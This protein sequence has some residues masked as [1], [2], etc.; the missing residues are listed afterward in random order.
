MQNINERIYW[1]K[2]SKIQKI[3]PYLT[4]DTTCDVVIIGG[5]ISG[6]LT[7]YFLAKAGANVVVIEKNIV[8]YGATISAPATLEY[9][10]DMDM[11]KL[12]KMKGAKEANRIYKICLEAIDIIEKIDD[13]FEKPTGFKR[14]DSIYF[15]NKFM[16]K[17]NMIK[18]FSARKEAGFDTLFLDSHSVLNISSA[19]L[20]KNASAV[21]NPYMFTQGLFEYLS[22][23]KNVRIY[24]N[25]EIRKIAPMYDR[26]ECK[27]NNDFKITSNSAIFTSG[28]ETLKYL[29]NINV[30]L[31]KSFS[32]VTKPLIDKEYLKNRN[33]NFTARESGDPYHYIRFDNNGRIIFSGENTKMSEKFMDKKF[34]NN[35]ANDKYKRL[36]NSM[37]KL[38][39]NT[40]NI[41]IEYAFS[42]TFVN[43]KDNLPIIDEMPNMPN[44]FCNLGFGTNG[45]IY[46]AIG[47][48]MLKNAVNGLYTKDMN[49][50]KI[51]R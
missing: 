23:F 3:Y 33:I 49:M 18:E 29:D 27:T 36:T 28:I 32:V 47:A 45:I 38:F 39:N 19:I 11:Y 50:F 48:N 7:T 21:I 46:S 6:A 1:K 12:E 15:T 37:N 16:Q 8:G 41:P 35:I 10:S 31:Y 40:D 13:E 2:K 5:G 26:V 51:N 4:K 34:Y 25:T 44:C 30:D 43:T 14:Q 22:T 17:S 20:T 42:T 24:E 9:Q